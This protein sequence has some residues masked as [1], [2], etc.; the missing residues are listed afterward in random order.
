MTFPE[1]NYTLFPNEII[2]K[3]LPFLSETQLKI[4]IGFYRLGVPFDLDYS[5]FCVEK[6][7]KST[8]VDRN[9]IIPVLM[10][11][12]E[13]GLIPSHFSKDGV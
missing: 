5:Q 1:P 2:D 11:M 3:W 6:I 12:K 8:G 4:L 13:K 10:M 7:W 9:Q